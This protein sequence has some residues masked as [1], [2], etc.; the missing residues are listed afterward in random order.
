[1]Q[2]SKGLQSHVLS[3]HKLKENNH[4]TFLYLVWSG[5]AHRGPQTVGQ[6]HKGPKSQA[7]LM[8]AS[9]N[10][11]AKSQLWSLNKPLKYG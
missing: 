6:V 2:W 9:P 10:M 5:S 8:L 11:E 7:P 4:L 3:G 1:M